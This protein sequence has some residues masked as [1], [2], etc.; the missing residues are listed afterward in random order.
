MDDFYPSAQFPFLGV[1]VAWQNE[2][3]PPGTSPVG[4]NVRAFDRVQRMRGGSRAGLSRFLN[5]RVNGEAPIQMLATIVSVDAE[6]IG[7]SFDGLDFGF[8]GTYGGIGFTGIA[9]GTDETARGINGGGGYQPNVSFTFPKYRL[10]LSILDDEKAADGVTTARITGTHLDD[11]NQVAD[12]IFSERRQVELKASP[13]RDGHGDTEVTSGVCNFD[14]TNIYVETVTYS[15]RDITKRK[16]AVN[17][18]DVTWTEP[19]SSYTWTLSGGGTFATGTPVTLTVTTVPSGDTSFGAVIDSGGL[20]SGITFSGETVT[21]GTGE[22]LVT[23]NAAEA[24]S[25]TLHVLGADGNVSNQ[26]TI[27]WS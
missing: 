22:L 1:D 4:R 6:A 20:E 18:V 12:F 24:G 3:Q 14:V 2:T 15:A 9:Y 7:W 11:D 19:V 8:T 5:E 13:A 17:T 27:T 26:V 23:P 21:N 10:V 16:R 25:V